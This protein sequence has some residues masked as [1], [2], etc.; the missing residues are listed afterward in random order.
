[1]PWLSPDECQR[2]ET[3]DLQEVTVVE[4]R[5]IGESL[6]TGRPGLSMTS[7]PN[8][9]KETAK[10][11]GCG[12]D[13]E[14]VIWVRPD[15]TEL[16]PDALCPKCRRDKDHQEAIERCER[17]LEETKARQRDIWREQYGVSGIFL[18]KSFGNF[19]RELQ[20]KAF[21]AMKGFKGRSMV[22]LSPGVY[23]VGKTHL[24]CALANHIVGTTETA[25]FQHD[26]Y[27][28][29]KRP[30]PVYFTTESKLL[31]RIRRTYN[32]HDDPDA[33]T[34]DGIYN[35]LSRFPLLILD[36]VGKVRPKDYS[37]LQGVY[38]NIIDDRYVKEQQ[39]IL[40]TNLDYKEL[41][42]HIGGASSDRIREMCGKNGFIKMTGKSYRR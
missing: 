1:M 13:F 32:R 34:E 21:D 16:A 8:S 6:G 12:R 3:S 39:I 18:E 9:R 10:C 7:K 36:D 37:F 11:V 35:S 5:R 33:E 19:K 22:L 40:T 2:E 14:S 17:E 25:E 4:L 42:E 41:E 38:F 29:I 24:V 23:G 20:P 26:S 30:C 27:Y 28:I 15:G 31:A